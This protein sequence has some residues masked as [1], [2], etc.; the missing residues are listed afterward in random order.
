MLGTGRLTIARAIGR[1]LILGEVWEVEFRKFSEKK[2]ESIVGIRTHAHSFDGP[3]QLPLAHRDTAAELC[4]N[5][6]FIIQLF[7][8]S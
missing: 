3:V 2:N 4:I 1:I 7:L 8:V 6:S 5:H